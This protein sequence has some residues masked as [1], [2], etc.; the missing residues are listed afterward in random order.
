MRRRLTLL[1]LVLAVAAATFTLKY[2]VK[3]LEEEYATLRHQLLGEQQA[4][5]VLKAE[6]SYLNRPRDLEQRA[7]EFLE[8]QPLTAAQ[9]GMLADL[10][11]RPGPERTVDASPGSVPPG[12]GPQAVLA[13]ARS[14]E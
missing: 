4:I 1:W 3:G 9:I 5:H 11:F 6:W 13:R 2:E 7:A 14:A 8:L 12:L 10:P